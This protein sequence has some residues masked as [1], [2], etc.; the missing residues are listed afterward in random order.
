DIVRACLGA[1]AAAYAQFPVHYGNAVAD[2][3]SSVLTGGFAVAQA[4]TSVR[5]CG[6]SAKQLLC[7]GAGGQSLV[8]HESPCSV[9]IAVTHNDSYFLFS[10]IGFYAQDGSQLL[11]YFRSSYRTP[12]CTYGV[13]GG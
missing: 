4:H 8:F 1:H 7:S 9:V 10:H 3:D 6:Q 5:T 12:C 2:L 13:V 11:G